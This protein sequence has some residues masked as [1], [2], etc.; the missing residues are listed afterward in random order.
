MNAVFEE[1]VKLHQRMI[2]QYSLSLTGNHFLAEDIV[3]ETF[4]TAWQKLQTEPGVENMGAWLRAITR[5]KVFEEFR[6]LNRH[7]LCLAE[8]VAL[9]VEKIQASSEQG[10]DDDR[11]SH[12]LHHCFDQLA[13]H[14]RQ[15]VSMRYGQRLSAIE[16]GEA[17]GK[18]Q[19]NV[20]MILSRIRG[21]LRECMAKGLAVEP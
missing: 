4:V 3:Q 18:S 17:V 12:V 11:L 14:M 1:T 10:G 16:I 15:I 6:K 20:N 19:D 9:R 5:R 8:D 2:Y 13:E 7:P 21:K